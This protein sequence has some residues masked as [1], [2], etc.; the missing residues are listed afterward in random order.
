ML[1]K[2]GYLSGQFYMIMDCCGG[3]K[4]KCE[5]SKTQINTDNISKKG[6]VMGVKEYKFAGDYRHVLNEYHRQLDSLGEWQINFTPAKN[7]TYAFDQIGSG[8]LTVYNDDQKKVLQAYDKEMKDGGF[9][10][11]FIDG[12]TDKII[13][14]EA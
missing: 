2:N 14:N 3:A 13:N 5:F 11:F 12:V 7:Q 1:A 8:F 9:Y 6:Q 10:L 4:I